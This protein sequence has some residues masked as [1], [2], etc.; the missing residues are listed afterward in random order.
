MAKV[1]ISHSSRDDAFAGQLSTDLSIIGHAPWID[2]LEIRPGDSIVSRIQEGLR[3][4]RYAI[5]V[6]SLAAN[7][8]RWVD[9][10]WKEKLWD[11]II[12]QRVK[13]IPVLKEPCE[14][15]L[16][17][18][19]F[20]YADFT[21]SYAVGF[22]ILCMTLKSSTFNPQ[23]PADILDIDFLH[24]IEHAAKTHH[25]DHVRVACAHTV[26]SCRPDR[27]KP[28]L[29]DALNDLSEKVRMHAK[30]LLEGAY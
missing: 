14:I 30:I 16:F 20:R 13:I 12:D 26:W 1:F 28:I 27:A 10:E 22:S 23:S 8:S 15:P 21:K 17:L 9:T 29:E 11:S 6:L 5:V 18:R 24:A 25:E 3:D 2:D 4:C 19:N 7:K